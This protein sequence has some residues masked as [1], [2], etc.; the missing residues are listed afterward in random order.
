LDPGRGATV[1]NF[2]GELPGLSVFF[3]DSDLILH[4]Y[5]T[6]SRLDMLLSTYHL[7]DRT[8][9]GRQEGKGTAW[10]PARPPGSGTTT[11]IA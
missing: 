4:S 6:Y 2:C 5:S 1:Y 7:L 9:Q 8:P 11:R 3:R 10:R